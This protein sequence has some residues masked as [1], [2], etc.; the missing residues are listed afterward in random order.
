MK[1]FL[2]KLHRVHSRK[3]N[4]FLDHFQI[5]KFLLPAVTQLEVYQEYKN[6]N[7]CSFTFS[8]FINTEFFCGIFEIFFEK[9][10]IKRNAWHRERVKL[11]N[12]LLRWNFDWF[13][14]INWVY[15]NWIKKL[16]NTNQNTIEKKHGIKTY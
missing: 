9:F 11:S 2:Q 13:C 7:K 1:N 4:G 14:I 10:K 16:K 5:S 12:E 15:P 6:F 3:S 8:I